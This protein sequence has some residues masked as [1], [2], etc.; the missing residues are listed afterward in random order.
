M[1]YELK[2]SLEI[3]TLLDF[4]TAKVSKNAITINLYN[5]IFLNC[6]Y[7]I[8]PWRD[9]L[10]LMLQ[11]Y[12]VFSHNHKSTR[13]VL[14]LF[15]ILKLLCFSRNNFK[16]W[17]LLLPNL[18]IQTFIVEKNWRAVQSWM[19]QEFKWVIIIHFIWPYI[20]PWW[21][22]CAYLDMYVTTF[23]SIPCLSNS[24]H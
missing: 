18:T 19:K 13:L 8:N 21:L 2:P 20:Q 22:G 5:K 11:L 17:S 24:E 6:K 7:A 9:F 4:E 12:G 14:T 3:M 16:N 23:L 10:C 1:H 15:N